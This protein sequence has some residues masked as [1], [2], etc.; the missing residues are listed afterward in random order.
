MQINKSSGISTNLSEIN[1]TPLVDVMLVLL[2]IFMVTAP[3]MVPNPSKIRVDLPSAHTN[4]KIGKKDLIIA[5]DDKNII[6][7]EYYVRIGKKDEYVVKETDEYNLER[8]LNSFFEK[9]ADEKKIVF[10]KGDKSIKYGFLIHIMDILKKAGV[11]TIGMIV[12][13][14]KKKGGA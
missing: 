6:K 5:I 8:D 3:M 10:L 13:K 7:M 4:D 2:I 1:V 9:K 12:K 14:E 11:E